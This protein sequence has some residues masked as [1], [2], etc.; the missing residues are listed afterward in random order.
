MTTVPKTIEEYLAQLN[1]ALAD[2]DPAL[3]QDA[4]Y[5]A[6][7]YLRSE[8]AEHPEW[9]E[10]AMLAN[11]ATS[12]GAPEEVADIYRDKEVQ[13]E[14]ALRAPAR[15]LRKSA[16]G[17][18]FG[19]LGDPLAYSSLFYM[20]LSL[21]T[22]IFYFVW[23]VTGLSLSLGLCI[24]IIGLPFAALFIST[25]RAL[26]LVEGRLIEA[27]LGE[28]MPR[29]PLYADRGKTFGARVKGMF[30]DPR[31]WSTLLYMLLKLPLGIIYFVFA[32]AGLSMSAGFAVLIIGV[33][34]FLMF[35]A[36]GR[37]VSL[38]E[39]RLIE[40]MTGVRMPRR[41]V[42]QGHAS[43]FLARIGEMLRDR[44]TWSTIA[45]FVLMLPIG[46][47]Y[48]VTA[49]VGLVVSLTFIALPI[50]AVL[51]RAGW[52]GMS[53]VEVFS[54]AQ[55][56]WLFDTWIAIPILGVAGVLLLTSLMHL[57]RGVGKVHAMFAKSMLVARAAPNAADAAASGEALAA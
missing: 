15:P 14:T 36:I 41:P 52:F 55:P 44:R 49:V 45:Y 21:A 56:E 28:R 20:I 48:F 9:D 11:V 37:V 4:Q 17:K 27:M 7:E 42:Y 46:I 38:A 31:T 50:A 57:A 6:E 32:V 51:S 19:V 39:G 3:K 8:L 12:Y 54:H 16:L 30:V 40:A 29:R 25:V 1:A 47:L 23:T 13:V 22:G 43:G 35:V 34:F 24:L 5:D 26:A 53:G 10:A 33:P 18:F 2:A